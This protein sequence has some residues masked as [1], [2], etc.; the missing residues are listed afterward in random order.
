M[1]C[2][3]SASFFFFWESTWES[4]ITHCF[5]SHLNCTE[6]RVTTTFHQSTFTLESLSVQKPA[7]SFKNKSWPL[8]IE[9]SC[10]EYH[11]QWGGVVYQDSSLIHFGKFLVQLE[12]IPWASFLFVQCPHGNRDLLE[13]SL[14]RCGSIQTLR[15]FCSHWS[16]PCHCCH[17]CYVTCTRG[18]WGVTVCCQGMTVVSGLHDRALKL[19][20]GRTWINFKQ[21]PDH[22][23]S[24]MWS[25]MGLW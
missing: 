8:G 2:E 5:C 24:G 12:S 10:P 22:R 18:Q 14:Y 19:V 16:S 23:W 21:E 17:F 15:S 3:L 4:L 1:V 6:C 25:K 20:S 13:F 9:R 11:D 7:L